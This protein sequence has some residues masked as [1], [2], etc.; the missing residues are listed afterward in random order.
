MILEECKRGLAHQRSSSFPNKVQN[1]TLFSFSSMNQIK[2][3]KQHKSLNRD[4]KHFM[5]MQPT[6]VMTMTT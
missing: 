1:H 3:I 5:L 2:K 6:Q 4:K